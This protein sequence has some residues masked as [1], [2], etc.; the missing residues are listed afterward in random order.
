[1]FSFL[2]NSNNANLKNSF[3]KGIVLAA[4]SIIYAISRLFGFISKPMLLLDI[5]IIILFL[6]S[7][8][9]IFFNFYIKSVPK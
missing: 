3:G 9:L 2:F 8:F 4:S 6:Y 7:I 5:F 1:M